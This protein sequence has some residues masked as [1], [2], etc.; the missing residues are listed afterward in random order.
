MPRPITGSEARMNLWK[1]SQDLVF[2]MAAFPE[3]P[4]GPSW[5]ATCEQRAAHLRAFIHIASM[6]EAELHYKLCGPV[7]MRPRRDYTAG[8]R[9]ATEEAIRLMRAE[10][11][12]QVQAFV[13]FNEPGETGIPPW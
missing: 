13:L 9:P 12:G 10:L 3:F 7:P 6:G 8:L 2:I 1:G 11:A 4:S 5:K